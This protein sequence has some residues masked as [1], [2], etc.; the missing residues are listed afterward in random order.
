MKKLDIVSYSYIV[1]VKSRF[2]NQYIIIFSTKLFTSI[3]TITT[4][5]NNN[6][7]YFYI[8]FETYYNYVRIL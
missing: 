3:Y 7:N 8:S 5:S 4:T 2:F 6:N 1:N